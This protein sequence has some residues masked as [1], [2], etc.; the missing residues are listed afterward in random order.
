MM[1]GG[2]ERERNGEAAEEAAMDRLTAENRCVAKL[3]QESG[4]ERYSEQETDYD[5]CQ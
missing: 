2:M 5:K 4:R 3:R 1:D